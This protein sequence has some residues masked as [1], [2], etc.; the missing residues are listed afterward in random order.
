MIRIEKCLFVNRAPFKND[1]ELSFQD[2]INVLCGLNGRGET[3][4]LSY[5]VDAI[6]EDS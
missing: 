1:L 5:I 3:T 2:G 6:Q 4:I